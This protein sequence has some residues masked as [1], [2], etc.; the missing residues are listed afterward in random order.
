MGTTVNIKEGQRNGNT[1]FKL[2]ETDVYFMKIVEP[3]LEENRF[4]EPSDDGTL[5]LQLTLRWEVTRVTDEQDDDLV[6]NAVWQR[7]APWYGVTRKGAPSQFKTLIDTLLEQDLLPDFDPDA[8]EFDIETL[9]GIEQRVSVEKYIK[10]KGQNVG[11][12]GNRVVTVM[13][14]RRAKKAAPVEKATPAV[15][16]PIRVGVVEDE[17]LPF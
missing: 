14:L 12:P 1:E 3:K 11:Q 5:P 9:S 4:A 8:D 16:K 17:E 6:G 7:L 2:L 13:P 15:K 10:T